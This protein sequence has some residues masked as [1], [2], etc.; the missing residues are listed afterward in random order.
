MDFGDFEITFREILV[1]IAITFVL[2]GI[3]A[4]ISGAIKNESYEKNENYYKSLKIKDDEEMFKYA[5]KT[6][7]GYVLAEGKV[8]AVDG[9]AVEEIEG[10]YFYVKK[11]REEYTMHTRQVAHTRTVENRTET[12][13]TT[14]IYY[15]WDYAGKEE[16]NTERF[17]FLGVEFEYG[18]IYFSNEIYKDT[19]YING[20][21]RYKY[22]IIPFEFEGTLFTYINNN[23]INQNKFFTNNTVDNVI[24]SKEKESEIGSKIFWGIWIL[25]IIA[26]DFFYV[27][28]ENEYL[29]V[30]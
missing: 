30:R 24:E 8:Q 20:E 18:K 9:V 21:L 15:T 26:V 5:I 23:T 27:Y 29:E 13:Y 28:L 19:K 11:V 22:Y 25:L 7:V 6:N 12:Y 3:G 14:E 17:R 2:I 4:L 10:K 16:F 1:A